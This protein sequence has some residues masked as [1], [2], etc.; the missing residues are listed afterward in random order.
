AGN[1]PRDRRAIPRRRRPVPGPHR[2]VRRAAPDAVRLSIA[3]GRFKSIGAVLAARAPC[4][5]APPR[6]ERSRA[7]RTRAAGHLDEAPTDGWSA[8]QSLRARAA[9][10]EP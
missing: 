10:A 6:P 8:C 9:T 5:R 4:L 3:G 7:A 2:T 1:R